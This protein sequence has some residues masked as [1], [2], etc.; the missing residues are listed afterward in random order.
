MPT[1]AKYQSDLQIR[2][3]Q[4]A[5]TTVRL[6]NPSLDDLSIP[7]EGE[8]IVLRAQEITELPHHKAMVAKES[9]LDHLM[10]KETDHNTATSILR[11]R[12]E[13]EVLV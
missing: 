7:Y 3:E 11:K 9:L 2:A 13:G 10:N 12:W 6:Y 8:A 5:K 4:R 1:M